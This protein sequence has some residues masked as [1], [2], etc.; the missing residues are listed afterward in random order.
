[1]NKSNLIIF[2]IILSTLAP[3]IL[4]TLHLSFFITLPSILLT[5]SKGYLF[6]ESILAIV[7]TLIISIILYFR[8]KI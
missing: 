3:G 7:L 2:S 4:A 5:T 1:M 8:K 6:L